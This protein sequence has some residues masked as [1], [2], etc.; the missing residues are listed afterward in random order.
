MGWT[1]RA[2]AL[3]GYQVLLLRQDLERTTRTHLSDPDPDVAATAF[4]SG[5]S[6]L[7]HPAH[8]PTGR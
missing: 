5:P 2:P 1:D 4:K 7:D 3:S 8:Q 6:V